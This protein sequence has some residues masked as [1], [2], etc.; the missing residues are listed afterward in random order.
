M[1]FKL[2]YLRDYIAASGI[3]SVFLWIIKIIVVVIVGFLVAIAVGKTA[4][5]QDGS[6][7]PNLQAGDVVLLN[8]FVYQVGGPARGDV[9]AFKLSDDEMAS[10]HIK[11]VI[12]LPGETIQIVDGKILIDGKE[13]KESMNFP[14]IENPGIAEEVVKLKSNQYFVLGDNRNSSEDSRFLDVGV[15]DKKQMSGK[16]WFLISPEERAGWVK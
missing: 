6:M 1:F 14:L 12:G 3:K 8:R 5:M 15:I 11:R 16:V 4:I 2:R 7:E 10:I 13:Y 9:I